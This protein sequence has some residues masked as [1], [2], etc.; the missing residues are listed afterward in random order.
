MLA[1]SEWQQ[2]FALTFV[3]LAAGYVAWRVRSFC[4][5]DSRGAGCGSCSVN[6]T[7]E[8]RAPKILPLSQIEDWTGEEDRRLN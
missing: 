6:S 8:S 4:S 3:G 2:I 5:R 7:A 1:I